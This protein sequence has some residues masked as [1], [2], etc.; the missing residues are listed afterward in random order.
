M[1]VRFLPDRSPFL[2]APTTVDADATAW[3]ASVVTNGGTVSAG[4]LVTV[5]MFVQAEKAAGTWARTDDYWGLWGENAPQALTSL[6][7]RRLAAAVAA[8]TFVAD[9]HYAFNGT[10][11]YITTGFIP[12][13]HAVAMAGDNLRIAVYERTNAITSI[14]AGTTDNAT[15]ALYI[16]PHSTSHIFVGACNASVNIVSGVGD[17]SGFS[18]ASRAPAATSLVA[19]NDGAALGSLAWGASAAVLPTREIYLGCVNNVGVAGSFGACSL[20]LVCV[21]ASLT[22]PQEAAQYANVQAWATAIGANV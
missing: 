20:G 6:K 14:R 19:W 22:A 11:Q 2:R 8:P 10:T 17:M 18:A 21:G 7:Q 4:R 13:T 15:R 5:A 16:T 3:A 12:G 1:G 9:R